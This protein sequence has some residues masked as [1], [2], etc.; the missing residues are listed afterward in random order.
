MADRLSERIAKL[1]EPLDDVDY[2][3]KKLQEELK[4]DEDSVH[5][6]RHLADVPQYLESA[7]ELLDKA[8][9][10]IENAEIA[11]RMGGR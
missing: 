11:A 8:M 7:R 3:V 9:D 1:I 5:Q 6:T 10:E 2:I 4:A